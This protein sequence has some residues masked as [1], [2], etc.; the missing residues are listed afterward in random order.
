MKGS[1]ASGA[2]A[3]LVA[4]TETE[5]LSQSFE[6]LQGSNLELKLSNPNLLLEL[7]LKCSE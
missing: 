7:I 2:T 1:F 4:K 6:E 5:K 3:S